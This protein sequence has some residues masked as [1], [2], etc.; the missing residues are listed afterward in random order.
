L[1]EMKIDGGLIFS[2][3]AL[4]DL[5]RM[6]EVIRTMFNLTI[7]SLKKT[8][9]SHMKE[10]ESLENRL[11]DMSREV[12]AG[13]ARRLEEGRCTL[14]AGLIF[15]DVVNYLERIADH[16]LKACVSGAVMAEATHNGR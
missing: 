12:Q 8:D 5:R 14:E 16:V 15:L 6:Q 10:V 4:K 11:D 7:E 9:G 3:E 13:H 2:R 1:A